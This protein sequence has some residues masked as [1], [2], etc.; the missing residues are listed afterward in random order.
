M[1]HFFVLFQSVSLFSMDNA[2]F[3]AVTSVSTDVILLCYA[4]IMN[5]L[6]SFEAFY[7]WSF[8]MCQSRLTYKMIFSLIHIALA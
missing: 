4:G 6:F 2:S 3:A 8:T 7:N 1:F 5:I